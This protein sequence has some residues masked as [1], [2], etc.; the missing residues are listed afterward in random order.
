MLGGILKLWH[1]SQ[2]WRNVPCRHDQ[3]CSGWYGPMWNPPFRNRHPS[4]ITQGNWECRETEWQS[5]VIFI[6]LW[7]QTSQTIHHVSQLFSFLFLVLFFFFGQRINCGHF[8]QALLRRL[9]S[10]FYHQNSISSYGLQY[11]LFKQLSLEHW[12]FPKHSVSQTR[13]AMNIFAHVCSCGTQSCLEKFTFCQKRDRAGLSRA[14]V[15]QHFGPEGN[16][17]SITSSPCDTATSFF[18]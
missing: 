2:G 4:S 1:S 8:P 7:T 17:S 15:R 10:S 16:S 3:A 14:R 6:S 9:T 12:R 11:K 13:G 5:P 18:L